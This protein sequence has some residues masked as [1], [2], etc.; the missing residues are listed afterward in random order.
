MLY[1]RYK[2]AKCEAR[3]KGQGRR[4]YIYIYIYKSLDIHISLGYSPEKAQRDIV[5][6]VQMESMDDP[7]KKLICIFQLKNKIV[8]E[9]VGCRNANRKAVKRFVYPT[10]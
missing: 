1:T 2:F 7:K 8:E 10:N 4:I 5:S 6:C 3:G 9:D